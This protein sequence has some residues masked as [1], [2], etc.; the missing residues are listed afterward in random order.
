MKRRIWLL[1]LFLACLA[2]VS[3]AG[4]HAATWTF[5]PELKRLNAGGT[6]LPEGT[7]KV[8]REGLRVGL[9]INVSTDGVNPIDD[10]A[11]GFDLLAGAIHFSSAELAMGDIGAMVQ[12]LQDGEGWTRSPGT[13]LN[14][15]AAQDGDLGPPS[16][17][18]TEDSWIFFWDDLTRA[19]PRGAWCMPGSNRSC[20]IFLGVL[21]V[22]LANLSDGASGMLTLSVGGVGSAQEAIS[23]GA[24]H[25]RADETSQPGNSVTYTICSASGCPVSASFAAA[26]YAAGE[27]ES[28]EVTVT[29]DAAPGREVTI[30]IQATGVGADLY[31]LSA[32]SVTFGPED[33]SRS[34]MVTAVENDAD[35][36]PET[37]DLD[38]TFGELP[39]PVSAGALA[40]ATVAITDNDDPS[41]TVAFGRE[42]YAA[43]EG[44]DPV[45]VTVVL[46][47][48]PERMVTIPIMA[49]VE[50]GATSDD[51]SVAPESVTFGPNETEKRISVT[52]VDDNARD[53]DERLTLGFGDLPEGVVAGGSGGDPATA[54]VMLIDDDSDRALMVM[55]GTPPRR[56]WKRAARLKSR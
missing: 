24:M 46:S 51:F 32:E 17:S 16:G 45:M 42:E 55:L 35:A 36:N 9:Y 47:A 54:T 18:G 49:R 28:V 41:V 20:E 34:F 29:L 2:T 25:G 30:P 21:T 12:Q 40:N 19:D 37:M 8:V 1:T 44:G 22:P 10:S 53:R 50:G 6:E 48:A 11:L 7:A 13:N 14:F 52:A 33:T 23:V 4:V 56:P 27:G 31:N 5:T 3:A 15:D 39:A 43:M 38:L 26:S